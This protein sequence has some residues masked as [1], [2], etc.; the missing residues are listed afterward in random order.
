MTDLDPAE[1]AWIAA[2][3]DAQWTGAETGTRG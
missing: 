1:V 2:A 3:W